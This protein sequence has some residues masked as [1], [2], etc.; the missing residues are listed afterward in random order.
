MYKIDLAWHVVCGRWEVD[1][2]VA[3][4]DIT[5]YKSRD[6]RYNLFLKL[7]HSDKIIYK[8]PWGPELIYYDREDNMTTGQLGVVWATSQR[9]RTIEEQIRL[10]I[11]RQF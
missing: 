8:G 9:A 1:A 2:L 10:Q 5:E 6:H 4:Q 3:Q 7:K 11:K